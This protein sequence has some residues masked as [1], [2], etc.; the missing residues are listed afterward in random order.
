MLCCG[1]VAPRTTRRK[2]R[3]GM[4]LPSSSPT[5]LWLKTLPSMSRSSLHPKG[6][7]CRVRAAPG[8]GCERRG[9]A[10][11]GAARRGK[12]R[13]GAARAASTRRSTCVRTADLPF[14]E[15]EREVEREDGEQVDKV[16]GSD[17][18]GELLRAGAEATHVLSAARW[19]TPWAHGATPGS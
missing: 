5:A 18:E 7:I 13:Q 1:S 17:E 9:K 12:A 3:F 11:Q 14:A 10:R 2:P 4:P 6:S 16:E 15:T 19:Q 8:V